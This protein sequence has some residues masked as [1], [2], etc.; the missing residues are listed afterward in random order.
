MATGL[1]R[2]MLRVLALVP[3][4]LGIAGC[5]D[6]PAD[7]DAPPTSTSSSTPTSAPPPSGGCE[8]DVAS[9]PLLPTWAAHGGSW[10]GF[11]QADPARPQGIR[12]EG[13]AEPGLGLL[14]DHAT[15]PFEAVDVQVQFALVSG[16]HPDGAGLVFHWDGGSYNIVRYSPSEGGWHLFTV[17]DGERS[18]VD[19]SPLP[20]APVL[21]AWCEW[22]TLRIVSDGAEVEVLQDGEAVL[23]ATLPSGASA[24]G[25]V[26]LFV[27]GDTVALF[28]GY[29]VAGA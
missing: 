26:G 16:R 14:V 23:H 18:K 7:T 2:T 13:E 20:D 5:L 6:D 4:L 15:G 12:G 10:S 19:T 9:L 25:Q 8:A 29:A 11:A 24:A 27:R 1:A 22:T 28:G 21:P 17:I 3:L